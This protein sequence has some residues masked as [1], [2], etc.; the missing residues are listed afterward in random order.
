MDDQFLQC[1]ANLGPPVTRYERGDV[2]G[3]NV[4]FVAG[5]RLVLRCL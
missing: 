1:C 4:V 5:P 3:E 2:M